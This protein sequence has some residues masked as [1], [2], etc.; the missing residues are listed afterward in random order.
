VS[1]GTLSG[2]WEI[3]L[4]STIMFVL[5][6][7]VTT[8]LHEIA[9]A[10]TG[11]MLGSQPILYDTF[12]EHRGLTDAG[13]ALTAVAGPLF[14]LIQGMILFAVFN[15]MHSAPR[16]AQLFVLWMAIHGLVNFFGYLINAPFAPYGDIGQ[17][18]AYL[19]F[20]RPALLGLLAIGVTANWA[21]GILATRPLLQLAPSAALI[22][23]PDARTHYVAHAAIVPWILG[24]AVIILIRYPPRFRITLIYP[25]VSGLFT[26]VSWTR[27]GNVADVEIGAAAAGRGPLWPW[28]VLLA[29]TL[30]LFRFVLARGI[31]LGRSA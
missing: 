22:A 1:G 24:A 15:R 3:I 14:S 9:H 16:M 13:E 11:L 20:S 5:A 6:F 23:S 12:V 10:L 21:I 29:A 8:I 25:A 17:V 2:T 19:R 7:I 27:A 26:I 28:V 18:A 30:V 4:D 31:H